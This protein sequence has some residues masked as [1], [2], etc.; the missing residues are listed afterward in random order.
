MREERGECSREIDFGCSL[1]EKMEVEQFQRLLVL[2][3]E[4]SV[5]SD[6]SQKQ[7]GKKGIFVEN[8]LDV[9]E[10]KLQGINVSTWV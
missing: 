6:F 5:T 7:R 8:D 4:A 2:L 10:V 3:G 1:P 9:A